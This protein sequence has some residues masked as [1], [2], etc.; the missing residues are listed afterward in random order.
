MTIYLTCDGYRSKFEVTRDHEDA[1]ASSS[2]RRDRSLHVFTRRIT[3]SHKA[4]KRQVSHLGVHQFFH[5]VCGQPKLGFV[6]RF[7]TTAEQVFRNALPLTQRKRHAQRK[8]ALALARPLVLNCSH[9]L[10]F[11]RPKGY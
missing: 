2:D 8:N 4:D 7:T 9:H 3:K 11:V 5:G 6:H 10:S 1:N